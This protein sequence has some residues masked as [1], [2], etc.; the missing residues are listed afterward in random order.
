RRQPAGEHDVADLALN[1]DLDERRQL[2]MH[3]DEVDAEGPRRQ[4][5]RRD[6]LGVELLGTHRAAGDDAEAAAIRD[7]GNEAA[8]RYP[9]HR[10]AHD[11]EIAAEKR[12]ARTPQELQLPARLRIGAT[13]L[14]QWPRRRGGRAMALGLLR[15]ASSP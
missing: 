9:G 7:R 15:H 10:A 14:G 3:R 1:A 2:R 11:C 8:L 6:D 5:A 12:R 13:A 4:R